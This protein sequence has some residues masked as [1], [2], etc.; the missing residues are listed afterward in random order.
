MRR[1]TL[2]LLGI[3]LLFSSIF[4]NVV[5][6]EFGHYAVA[7]H[8]ELEPEV[9][10]EQPVSLNSSYVLTVEPRVAYVSYNGSAFDLTYRD[11]WVALAGPAV[12]LC[13]SGLAFGGYLFARKKEKDLLAFAFLIILVPSL[14][15]TF[16]NLIPIARTD[17]FVM[18]SSLATL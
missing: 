15:S 7:E 18:L 2:F 11:F 9:H 16:V 17:G 1:I 14:I 8:F 4:A 6:H 5:L 12:N 3:F 10:F 13:F